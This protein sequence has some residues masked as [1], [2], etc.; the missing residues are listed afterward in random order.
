MESEFADANT[1][2]QDDLVSGQAC[3]IYS[4]VHEKEG[5]CPPYM[6]LDPRAIASA[7]LGLNKRGLI[8]TEI[9]K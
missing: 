9:I 3:Y 8:V 6:W 2:D 5:C 4:G 1:A 7:I